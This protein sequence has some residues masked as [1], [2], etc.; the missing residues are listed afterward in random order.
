MFEKYIQ[1][2]QRVEIAVKVVCGFLYTMIAICAAGVGHIIGMPRGDLG[3]F[4]SNALFGVIGAFIGLQV[5]SR[6]FGRSKKRDR[7]TLE[8]WKQWRGLPYG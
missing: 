6:L 4:A 5:V 3:N 1:L 2:Q 7:K 8:P